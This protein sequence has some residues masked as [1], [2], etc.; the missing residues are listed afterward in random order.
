MIKK[1]ET[2]IKS[3]L[4]REIKVGMPGYVA[5]RHED[6]RR[7]GDPDLSVTGLKLTSWW[8]AKHATPDFES[9]GIQDRVMDRLAQ[10]GFAR[11]LIY[12]EDGIDKAVFIVHPQNLARFRKANDMLDRK[13]ASHAWAPDFNH[14]F[15]VAFMV[16][17][18]RKF[19]DMLSTV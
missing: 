12:F 10:V 8:E 17:T 19:Y 18:H 16:S 3:A 6:V 11:Y 4:M 7:S 1:D 5:L 14:A 15:V 2:G 9:K 13:M